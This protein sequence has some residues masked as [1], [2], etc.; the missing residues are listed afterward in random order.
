LLRITEA[1]GYQI[2]HHVRECFLGTTWYLGDRPV[3]AI[4]DR[5]VVYGAEA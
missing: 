4:D 1:C 5:F 3:R 2:P